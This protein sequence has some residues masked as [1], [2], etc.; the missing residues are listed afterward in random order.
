MK[1][2]FK[3]GTLVV[4]ALAVCVLPARQVRAADDDDDAAY[5]FKV[6]NT[7]DAKITKLLASEDGETYATFDIGKGLEPGKSM[8]L[9]WDKSTNDTNCKWYIKAVFADE[10]ESPAKKFD[11]CEEDLELEF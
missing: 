8:T 9:K 5:T 2:P 1:N 7:T 10:S 3:L 4:L 6:H 11:F